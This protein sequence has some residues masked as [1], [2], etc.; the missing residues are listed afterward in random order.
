MTS[1]LLL[2]LPTG[3]FPNKPL[4]YFPSPTCVLHALPIASSLTSSLNTSKDAPP[5][6]ATSV[7]LSQR[8]RTSAG[9]KAPEPEQLNSR[10]SGSILETARFHTDRVLIHNSVQFTQDH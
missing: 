6:E 1:S 9:D 7:S 5:Y 8:S 3:L 4:T 10:S 2:D